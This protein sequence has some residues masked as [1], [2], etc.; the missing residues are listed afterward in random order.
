LKSTTTTIL[1]AFMALLMASPRPVSAQSGAWSEIVDGV[2]GRLWVSRSG[3]TLNETEL[4]DVYIELRNVSGGLTPIEIYYDTV[5]P[6]LS[7]DVVDAEGHA[8]QNPTP[9]V[10]DILQPEPFWLTLPQG[11]SLQFIVSVSG[12]GIPKRGGIMIQMPCGDWALKSGGRSLFLRAKITALPRQ[13]DSGHRAW[14]GTLSL[15]PA[16]IPD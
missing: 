8:I 4:T 7:C 11:G 2:Q 12:Y 9:S 1:I 10:A 14:H 13:E 15:P 6:I 16:A 5:H 3:D